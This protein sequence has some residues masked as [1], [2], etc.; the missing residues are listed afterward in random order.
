MTEPDPRWARLEARLDRL[1]DKLTRLTD[2]V[3]RAVPLVG[4]ATDIADDAARRVAGRRIDLDERAIAAFEALERLSAPSTLAALGRLAERAERLE[5]LVA[6][7]A[8][9]EDHVALALDTVDHE[10]ARYG[11]MG[12]DVDERTANLRDL[13]LR[14]SDPR[15]AAVLVRASEPATL[16]I[17][18]RVIERTQQFETLVD[19]A[20]GFEDHLAMVIDTFD[21]W[22]AAVGRDGTDLESRL[23]LATEMF[24]ALT[25]P[26]LA[27]AAA[28]LTARLP[29]LAALARAADD[30]GLL[31]PERVA[32]VASLAGALPEALA[33][34]PAPVGP[35]GAVQALFQP[36]SRRALGFALALIRRLAARLPTPSN[37][38]EA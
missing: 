33:D 18:E 29:Q 19:L 15:V 27:R 24:R 14:L 31:R 1:E 16:R 21:A 9:F 22:A 25:D 8:G 36:D 30:A 38:T 13:V 32:E 20:G 12:V 10:I 6:L 34:R 3:D 28:D 5:P 23:T 7:A 17:A 2:L 35:F 4:M 37:R 26:A 11:A